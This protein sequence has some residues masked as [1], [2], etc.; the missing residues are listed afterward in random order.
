MHW[1]PESLAAAAGGTL[2][3]R[4]ERAIAGAFIDSRTPLR[5]G[6]FVPLVAARDGHEF[7]PAALAGGAS[8]VLVGPGRAAPEGDFTVVA[9]ADTLLALQALA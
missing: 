8:A 4:S 5:E 1:S 6:L 7:I 3:R 2:M 9:V